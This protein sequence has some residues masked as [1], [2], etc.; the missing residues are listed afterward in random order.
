M[1]P[2]RHLRPQLSRLNQMGYKLFNINYITISILIAH[3]HRISTKINKSSWNIIGY[4]LSF[5]FIQFTIPSLAQTTA[6]PTEIPLP[7]PN[8]PNFNDMDYSF[9]CFDSDEVANK[10]QKCKYS[11]SAE[12]FEFRFWKLRKV[13][14]K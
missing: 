7:D 8:L 2:K 4:L 14:V 11:I 13:A 3:N 10:Y 6:A 5:N 1:K 12:W 9:S